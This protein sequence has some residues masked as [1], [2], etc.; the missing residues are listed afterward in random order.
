VR[1]K[2]AVTKLLAEKEA[3]L[4]KLKLSRYDRSG[5]YSYDD[6]S[7]G[8]MAGGSSYDERMVGDE[9]LEN[10][11]SDHER[12]IKILRQC[13]KNPSANSVNDILYDQDQL[14][15]EIK[16]RLKSGSEVTVAPEVKER[17]VKISKA[18]LKKLKEAAPGLQKLNE[19]CEAQ[20]VKLG[21]DSVL[22]VTSQIQD[23][24]IA[25]ALVLAP[26]HDVYDVIE[27]SV[28]LPK[29]D[30]QKVAQIETEGKEQQSGEAALFTVPHLPNGYEDLAKVLNQ[31]F[32]D[33]FG[34]PL[35]GKFLRKL[36]QDRFLIEGDRIDLRDI[37]QGLAG[38]QPDMKI[39]SAK[40]PKDNQT[41]VFKKRPDV[42][43]ALAR[44]KA[45]K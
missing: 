5:S 35:D 40:T 15:E 29:P 23:S 1:L 12:E 19:A 42:Q 8:S 43:T 37:V 45:K 16:K 34:K 25:G 21:M 6:D 2:R 17:C 3:T 20:G 7:S 24:D 14:K 18:I 28:N 32:A 31:K 27:E 10:L 44:I 11:I 39:Y 26:E 13:L 41:N 33:K 38:Q 9:E 22:K 4:E 30:P 36:Y